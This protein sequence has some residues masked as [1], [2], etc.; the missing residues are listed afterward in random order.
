M[1]A[2]TKTVVVEICDMCHDKEAWS[3]GCDG[4]G[5]ALC[6]DC[7]EAN[8]QEFQGELFIR[9]SRDLRLCTSCVAKQFAK[10]TALF[11]AYQQVAAL[12]AECKAWNESFCARRKVAEERVKT[13]RGDK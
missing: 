10:P 1:S 7:R 13:L 4:C 5:V 9:S 8:T 11:S 6:Y 2:V 12:K 3:K